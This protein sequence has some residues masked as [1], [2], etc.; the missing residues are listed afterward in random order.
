M[1]GGGEPPIGR[2][3]V[4][5]QH[6]GVV[7]AE[8]RLGVVEAATRSDA[9]DDHALAGERPQPRPMP[10]H[11]PAGLIRRHNRADPDPAHQ[12][13][14]CGRRPPARPMKRL[15][16]PT[17]GHLEAE[18]TQQAGDLGRRQAQPL[19]QPH[20]ERDRPRADLH[21]SRAQRI[22]GLL[23]MAGLDASP[24]A[25]AAT[26]LKVVAGHHRRARRRQ[27]FLVL[28]GHPFHLQL[29]AAVR[30]DRRQPHTD[31]PVD[32]LGAGRQATRP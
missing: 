21:P 2:P 25:A 1:G 31:H 28:A 32:P 29:V 6:P 27:V 4:A 15:D 30:A 20:G 3:P 23:G 7:A 16:H 14:P 22:G 8:H 12:R 18:L 13:V 5:F 11:P 10:R 19:G 9:V 24:A 26:D 17:R